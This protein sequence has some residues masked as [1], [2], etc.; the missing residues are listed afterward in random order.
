M[1][2][3]I[4]TIVMATDLGADAPEVLRYAETLAMCCRAKRVLVHAV[5]P[6]PAHAAAMVAEAISAERAQAVHREGMEK[7]RAKTRSKIEALF[8]V[9]SV[10]ATK[11]PVEVPEIRIVEGPAADTILEQATSARAD[12][13]VMGTH[14]HSV[15][16]E[17]M[18]GSVARKV[19]QCSTL[20]VLL[21]PCGGTPT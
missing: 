10:G 19:V 2:P 11:T 21:V 14:R 7:Y 17:L 15:L 6:V 13:I 1:L 9:E 12:V 3:N 4:E 8:E 16:G 18:L 5:E 20:P